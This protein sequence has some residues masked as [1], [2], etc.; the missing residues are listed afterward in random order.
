MAV[1]VLRQR[2][3]RRRL[4]NIEEKDR[5]PVRLQ[6]PGGRVRWMRRWPNLDGS[7]NKSSLGANAILAVSMAVAPRPPL[8]GVWPAGC[9]AT[10]V[11]DGHPA[12][13]R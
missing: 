8:P 6:R 5:R 3:Y 1:A 11:G 10:W 7:D 13:V 4:A 9:I 2:G 12:T